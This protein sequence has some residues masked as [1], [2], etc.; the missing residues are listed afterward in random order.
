MK[1]NLTF[2]RQNIWCV[3]QT[4]TVKVR[5]L[6]SSRP[7]PAEFTFHFV[8]IGE[9]IKEKVGLT[10]GQALP[11]PRAGGDGN[12]SCAERLSA[13]DVVPGVTDDIHLLWAKLKAGMGGRTI[14]GARTKGIAVMMIVGERAEGKEMP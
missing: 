14:D 8:H 4:H 13:R 5:K 6:L 1:V 11:R 12:R 9:I 3:G 2:Q 7:S 10:L